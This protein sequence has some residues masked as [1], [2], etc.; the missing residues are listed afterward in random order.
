MGLQFNKHLL[1]TA[2]GLQEMGD[3]V[4]HMCSLPSRNQQHSV[5][6]ALNKLQGNFLLTEGKKKST[7]S[8]GRFGFSN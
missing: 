7:Q 3:T 4:G 1:N 5:M 2:Q 8:K 6:P